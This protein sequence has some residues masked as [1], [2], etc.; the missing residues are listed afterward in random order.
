MKKNHSSI[1][2]AQDYQEIGD[3]W[4]SKDLADLWD[5]TSP[6]E[7]DIDIQSEVTYYAVDY[8]ISKKIQESAKRRGVTSDTLLNMW[9]QEKLQEQTS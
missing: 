1:S 8:E 7:F 3:F 5:E 2:K 9:L 4:D 6:A